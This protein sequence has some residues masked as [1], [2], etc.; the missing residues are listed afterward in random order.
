MHNI[1]YHLS[2]TTKITSLS[3]GNQNGWFAN[4]NNAPP[5]FN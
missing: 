3:C 1:K 5:F 2:A 4:L